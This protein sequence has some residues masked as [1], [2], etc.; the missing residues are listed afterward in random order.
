MRLTLK[1]LRTGRR[2]VIEGND[3]ILSPDTTI[4]EVKGPIQ[5]HFGFSSEELLLT[6]DQP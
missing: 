5:M 3:A 1:W 6:L 2:S 4:A